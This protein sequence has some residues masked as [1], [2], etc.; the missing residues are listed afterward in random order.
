MIGF[1]HRDMKA[2]YSF[3]TKQTNDR[4]SKEE[5]AFP[6]EY[7]FKDVPD[8]EL[9]DSPDPIGVTLREMDIWGIER[10]MIGISPRYETSL[11]AIKRFP[12]RF[13]PSMLRA[14]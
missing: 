1:P 2:L 14:T 5:F 8:K 13:I 11:E 7:M 9:S 10:G 4:E 6:A 3:I 12:D